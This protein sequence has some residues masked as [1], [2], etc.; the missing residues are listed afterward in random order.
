MALAKRAPRLLVGTVGSVL[1][2]GASLVL[3]VLVHLNTPVLR[4]VAVS[5]VNAILAPSF[6]G[7]IRIERLASLNVFGLSGADV[8]LDDPDGRPVLVVHGLRARFETWAALRSVFAGKNDP[9]DIEVSALSI[10]SVDARLDSDPEGKLV[11]VDALSPRTPASP[12]TGGNARALRLVFGEIAVTHAW[13]HG[14][15]AGL[16]PLDVEVDGISGSFRDTPEGLEGDVS[17]L[18]VDAHRIANGADIQGELVAHVKKDSAENAPVEGRATW[19]GTAGR[20]AHTLQAW[21]SKGLVAAVVTVPPASGEDLQ[22]LW[23]AAPPGASATALVDVR[24]TLQDLGVRTTA[25]LGDASLDGTARVLNEDAIEFAVH[26]QANHL[27]GLVRLAQPV[28]GDAHLSA[29]GRID[30]GAKSIDAHLVAGVDR[31]AQGSTGLARVSIEGHARGPLG[32]PRLDATVHAREIVAQGVRLASLDLL[33]HGTAHGAHLSARAQGPDIPDVDASTD[34][35]LAGAGVRLD[36]ARV[37]LTRGSAR[38]QITARRVDLGGGVVRV[39]QARIEGAGAP[40]TG[41]L[42]AT[43]SSLRLRA[44]TRG[45]DLAYLA[46]IAHRENVLGAGTLAFDTDI[47]LRGDDGKAKATADLTGLSAVGISG[48]TAHL[49]VALDHH[50]V[51]GSVHA[52]AGA[53][54]ALDVVASCVRLGA[55]GA[56]SLVAWRTASGRIDLNG[57]A[58]LACIASTLSA[59]RRFLSNTVGVV[60]VSGHVSRDDNR[61]LTPDVQLSVRTEKLSVVP[62]TAATRDDDGVVVVTTP[63]W[64]IDGIDADAEVRVDGDTG[65][66]Q[67]SVTTHDAEGAL[68]TLNASTSRFPFR[69]LFSGGGRLASSM[70]TMPFDA[71]IA[72]PERKLK[73]L[74]PV[75]TRGAL[76]GRLQADATVSGTISAPSIDVTAALRHA[77]LVAGAPGLAVDFDLSGHYERDLGSASVKAHANGRELLNA[78]AGVDMSPPWKASA[79]VHASGFPLESIVF[80]DDK[81]VAGKLSGDLSVD[82]LH[83]DARSHADLSIDGL[84]VGSVNY[85]AAAIHFDFDGRSADGDVRI[86]QS[87]GFANAEAHAAATWGSALAPSLE[88]TQPLNVTLAA[89]NFRIAALLPFLGG[90]LDELDGRIDADTRVE[91]DP[92]DRKARLSGALALRRGTVEAAAGGGELH[93]IAAKLTF[94]P[95]G[96]VTLQDLTASGVSGR[97]E[98]NGSARL[99]GTK[100]QSARAAL[101]IPSQTPIPITAGGLEIGTVHGRFELTEVSSPTGAANL[102][103]EVPQLR[104]ALHEGSSAKAMGL[105]P[106]DKVQIGSPRDDGRSFVLIPLDPVRSQSPSKGGA[107]LVVETHFGD[108]QVV[109]GTDLKVDLDG[110]VSIKTS[111]ADAVTGQIRLKHG[112]TLKVRGKAFVVDSGTVTFVGDD[113]DNPE[114]VVKASWKAPDGTIVYANFRGPLKTGKVTL[115]SEPQL[116]QQEITQLLLFGTTDGQQAHG[117]GSNPGQSA[118]GTVGGQAVQPI[119]HALSELGLGAVTANV[120]TTQSTNPKPEVEIQVARDISLQL[121]VVLGQPPP[122]VNPDHTLL[123]VDWRFLSKWSLSTTLGDAGTTVFDLLWHKRY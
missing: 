94:S 83:D 27:E 102:K 104:V 74:P 1:L 92:R 52:N 117:S 75:L 50:H 20:V 36:A 25:R 58:D 54:G 3:A 77:R 116:P 26:G 32:D 40:I 9:W 53:L 121:A 71:R 93:D 61:D 21:T 67:A 73:D 91:L 24:G 115:T 43:S 111:D 28:Q 15:M 109:R 100:L 31:V 69:D 62:Q 45:L 30:L 80:L 86:V 113:P 97:L 123:T 35:I 48:A 119:N 98:A 110:R 114:V 99:D 66:L 8:T 23:P 18:T 89:K 39:D 41:D 72:I 46:R 42:A 68:A 44:S 14:R 11:L 65:L 37:A 76:G 90:A 106:M 12:S 4:R 10:D 118:V 85:K 79:R 47:D 5:R 57:H 84:S 81:L 2:F 108:V 96:V 120:D 34:L 51:D 33:G 105:S 87:D 60:F 16:R 78:E 29:T 63:P 70:R 19:S 55:G 17:H 49:D 82:G 95:E 22:S 103:V 7:T 6:R 107:R 101:L 59:T 64:R 56:A 13:L 88:P 122:G 38:A 112:G